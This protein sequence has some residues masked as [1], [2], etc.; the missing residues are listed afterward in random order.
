MLYVYLSTVYH[1]YLLTLIYLEGT[2]LIPQLKMILMYC[3][4]CQR[5]AECLTFVRMGC[6]CMNNPDRFCYI[7][8]N[9]V[10]PNHQAK[11]TD[12]VKKAYHN[13]WWIRI[14]H[15]LLIFAVKHVWRT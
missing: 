7:C 5:C 3:V 6:K 4:K 10:L 14:S 2:G 8:G 1:P 15:L 13:Y 9:V 11:I 12:F